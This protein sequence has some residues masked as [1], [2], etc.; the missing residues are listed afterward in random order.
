MDL[1][2]SRLS[3]QSWNKDRP[4]WKSSRNAWKEKIQY[5]YSWPGIYGLDLV[6]LWYELAHSNHPYRSN[7][8]CVYELKTVCN[9]FKWKFVKFDI[10][11]E[12]PND[13]YHR[14]NGRSHCEWDYLQI[15]WLNIDSNG[16]NIHST[17]H[18]CHFVE[19]DGEYYED[20]R[21]N[22]PGQWAPQIKDYD[23]NNPTDDFY[24]ATEVYWK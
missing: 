23:G 8:N 7:T 10:E 20:Q 3:I 12:D 6:V 16:T 17:G 5:H 19:K 11:D 9:N 22:R 2:A 1:G 18:L 24:T 14:H 15:K 4:K 13:N 21:G